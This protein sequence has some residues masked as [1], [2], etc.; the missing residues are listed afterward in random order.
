[1]AAAAARAADEKLGENILVLDLRGH[2]QVADFFVIVTG[3]VEAHLAAMVRAVA[4]RLAGLGCRP[5]SPRQSVNAGGWALMD[6]GPVVLHAF[7]PELRNYYDLELL[8]GDAPRIDWKSPA[9]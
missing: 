6:Y 5:L 9:G 3:R 2:S 7:T 8:W 1:M 4:E